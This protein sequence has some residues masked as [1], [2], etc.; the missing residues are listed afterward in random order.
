MKTNHSLAPR[1]YQ[2]NFQF[3][4][5]NES[6]SKSSVKRTASLFKNINSLAA[7]AE[8]AAT[9]FHS[10]QASEINLETPYTHN[11]T[12]SHLESFSESS[13]YILSSSCTNT[14]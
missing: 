6:R 14:G 12:L 13:F 8:A 4:K 5:L 3:E 11:G 10:L 1:Y 2:I 7:A 9:V